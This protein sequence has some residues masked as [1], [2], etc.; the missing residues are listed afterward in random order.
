MLGDHC[1]VI[2]S[3]SMISS[4]GLGGNG[5]RKRVTTTEPLVAEMFV[6]HNFGQVFHCTIFLTWSFVIQW[7]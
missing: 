4:E 7:H 6:T 5:G 3:G 1:S 2:L